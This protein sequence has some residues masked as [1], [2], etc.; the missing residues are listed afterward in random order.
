MVGIRFEQFRRS[1]LAILGIF[2]LAFG[3]LTFLLLR[4]GLSDSSG[5]PWTVIAASVG[6]ILVG[7]MTGAISRH[8]QS[9]CLKCSLD[10]LW[11]CLPTLLGSAFL[12]VISLR[13]RWDWQ[14]LRLTIWALGLLV[15]FGGGIVSLGHALS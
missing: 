14:G 10:L 12:Q 8:G 2:W 3:A 9:C 4:S 1:Q 13:G 7:P 11:M 15:W 6:T 5:H